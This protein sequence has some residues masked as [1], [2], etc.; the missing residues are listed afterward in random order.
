[1]DSNSDSFSTSIPPSVRS[2]TKERFDALLKNALK[3]VKN[4]ETEKLPKKMYE[5]DSTTASSENLLN[6]EELNLESLESQDNFM[7]NKFL[8]ES[9]LEVQDNTNHVKPPVPKPR[10]KTRHLEKTKSHSSHGT[11]EVTTPKVLKALSPASS[12]KTFVV[13]KDD[14]KIGET[15]VHNTPEKTIESNGS[16]QEKADLEV[17][18]KDLT[19][20]E[21]EELEEASSSHALEDSQP[22]KQSYDQIVS[23]II[24]KTEKLLIKSFLIH[25]VVKIH[26]VDANTGKYFMK[27]DKSRSVVFYYENQ[28]TDYIQPV[29]T[30]FYNLQEKRTLYPSW[31]ERITINEDFNYLASTN[32]MYFFEILDFFTMSQSHNQNLHKASF[33]GWHKI[34]FAFLK[35]IGKNNASNLNKKLRLQLYHINI[36]PKESP[37][38]CCLWEIWNSK[39]MKKYPSTLYVTINALTPPEKIIEVFRSKTP[40]QQERTSAKLH[41]ESIQKYETEEKIKKLTDTTRF[42]KRLK[43]F[44]FPNKC[45]AKIQSY[46]EGCFIHKFSN[47]GLYLACAVLVNEMYNVVTYSVPSFE[48]HKKYACHQKLIYSINWTCNDLYIITSSADNTIAVWDFNRDTFLQILPHPAF[49]YASNINSDSVIASGCYDGCVR[50]WTKDKQS[51]CFELH[52]EL[53]KHKGYVTSLCFSKHRSVLYSSDSV[54]E[55]LLWERSGDEWKLQKSMTILE[56]KNT[57]IN[58][59]LIFPNEKKILVHS[60]DSILR[61]VSLN[62]FCVLHWLQGSLNERVQ[63]FGSISPCGTYVMSGGENGVITIWN[64][65][66]GTCEKTISLSD[67]TMLNTIHCV[68]FHPNQNLITCSSLGKNSPVCA[69]SFEP[70]T[71]EKST[72]ENHR[73][74]NIFTISNRNDEHEEKFNFREILQKMDNLFQ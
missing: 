17:C 73:E 42:Q 9:Q 38:K 46:D 26:I 52:Q 3:C 49:V 14:Y 65:K 53:T 19:K 61:I 12:T 70:I 64:A 69:Y 63:M 67:E 13:E 45:V 71:D 56:L 44:E 30:H 8:S 50:I 37:D 41:D 36:E 28:E 27:S 1:M 11:F 20:N 25:P 32:V 47:N 48:E 66:T 74:R 59:I 62:S 35:P 34:C 33:K 72:R 18:E 6:R 22:N 40:L 5:Y 58:Q 16:I 55:I 60:R 51:K 57:I 7:L 68:Q 54:G 15:V 24:H 31:E 21:A 29:M 4:N 43:K 39:K 23:I 10:K 2:E